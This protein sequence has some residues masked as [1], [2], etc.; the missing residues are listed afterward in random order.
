MHNFLNTGK[1]G[2]VYLDDGNVKGLHISQY[3]RDHV[4]VSVGDLL[5]RY[6]PKVPEQCYKAEFVAVLDLAEASDVA[7]SS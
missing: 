3:Q 2:T 7:T 4:R 5:S 1:G 6:T